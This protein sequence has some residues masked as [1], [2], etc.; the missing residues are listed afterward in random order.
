M[1]PIVTWVVLANAR[2]AQVLENRGPGKGLQS[3]PEMAKTAVAARQYS[4]EP[5]LGHSIAGPGTSAVD[6][7]DPQE[8]ADIQFAKDV[9]AGL[10]RAHGKGRFD[11]LVLIAGPHML[12][13]LRKALTP[14]LQSAITGE[15]AKDLTA[16]PDDAV[17]RTVGEIIA[18]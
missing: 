3:L 17:A 2:D 8:Q 6:Q 1:K 14:G 13:L 9:I 7:G 11:R 5:G 4:S 16:A 12:G 15:I 18:I 10:H